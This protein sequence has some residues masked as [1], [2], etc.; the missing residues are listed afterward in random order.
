MRLHRFL[1][2]KF[3]EAVDIFDYVRTH[4]TSIIRPRY[5]RRRW[6]GNVPLQGAKR[7]VVFNHFDCRGAIHEYVEFYLRELRQQGFSIIFTSNSPRFPERSVEKLKPLASIILWRRN[8]GYDFGAF[9]D[10]IAEIPDLQALD[11]LLIT[12]DSMYGPLQD[13]AQVI[14]S[15]KADEADVWGITDS[16]DGRFHLQSYFLLFHPTAIRSQAFA[17]F[18]GRLPYFRRKRWVVRYGEIGLTPFFLSQGLRCKAIF[19]YRKLI[20]VMAAKIDSFLA[21]PSSGSDP[22]RRLYAERIAKSLR[23]GVPLNQTHFFW[24]QL[25]SNN[26]CPFIKRD[27]LQHNPMAIPYLHNWQQLISEVSNY[28]SEMIVRHLQATMRN[29]VY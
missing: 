5:I 27:L 6:M 15:A 25:I 29:R 4:M 9:K 1:I 14:K 17:K 23:E 8:V 18:W 20:G 24:D 2:K 7:I 11:M 3:T 21:S 12:N 26:G 10:G 13:F 28:D 22:E 19:P 16:W